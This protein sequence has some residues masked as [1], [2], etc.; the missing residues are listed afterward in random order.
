[1][2]DPQILHQNLR[3]WLW[4]WR[5]YV[6]TPTFIY[7]Y[8]TVNAPIPLISLSPSER[9]LKLLPFQEPISE[10]LLMDG[11]CFLS[12]NSDPD[13][14]KWWC[15]RDAVADQKYCEHHMDRG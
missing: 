15:S 6:K 4:F 14:K 7:K 11:R 3:L 12:N 9:P 13:G 2:T 10:T 1:M 5:E 8:I